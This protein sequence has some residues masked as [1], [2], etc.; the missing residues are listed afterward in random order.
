MGAGDGADV[1]PAGNDDGFIVGDWVYKIGD[2]V[3]FAVTLPKARK[4]ALNAGKRIEP[5]PD[6]GSHDGD[7]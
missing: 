7:A 2:P 6:A 4:A 5:N 3:L 1:V